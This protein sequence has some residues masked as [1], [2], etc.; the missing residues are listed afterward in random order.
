M[1]FKLIDKQDRMVLGEGRNMGIGF[2]FAKRVD[3]TLET[4]DP[5]S[6]CKDYLNDRVFSEFTGQPFQ[7]CGL[8]TTKQNI[9]NDGTGYLIM[10]VCKQKYQGS[11]RDYPAY[12]DDLAA[13]EKN[14]ANVQKLLNWLEQKLKLPKLTEVQKIEDNKF[15]CI[16][17]D[18]WMQGTYLISLY[19]LLA[20]MGIYYDGQTDPMKFL[21]NYKTGGDAYLVKS[22]MPKINQ[23]ISGNV[24]KQ[25]MEALVKSRNVHGNG[26]VSFAFPTLDTVAKKS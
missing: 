9:F 16:M 19:G 26:I 1:S 18:F 8:S 13:L 21:E 4:V 6:P 12:K 14:Y 7:A 5:I 15:V 22:A 3:N 20:R 25:D 11:L 23:M 10:S 17:P 2:A 24:P